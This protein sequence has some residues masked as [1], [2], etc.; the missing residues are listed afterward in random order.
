MCGQ[1]CPRS[2]AEPANSTTAVPSAMMEEAWCAE[3]VDTEDA[4]GLGVGDHFYETVRFI[5]GEGAAV[6]AE[7]EFA[8]L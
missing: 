4:V 1:V 3:D 7:I 8:A 6:G 2:S 5:H